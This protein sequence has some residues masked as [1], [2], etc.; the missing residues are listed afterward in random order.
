MKNKKKKF[1][2]KKKPMQVT[3]IWSAEQT[4]SLGFQYEMNISIGIKIEYY[5][6][7]QK[8]LPPIKK[9]KLNNYVKKIQKNFA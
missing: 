7:S 8:N 6:E 9:W 4:S 3:L 1:V 5:S 2:K